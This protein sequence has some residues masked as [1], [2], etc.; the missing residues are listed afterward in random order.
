MR[1]RH[2]GQARAVVLKNMMMRWACAHL[3]IHGAVPK[4]L[5]TIDDAHDVLCIV[6]V[7]VIGQEPHG[8]QV[9]ADSTLR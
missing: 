8:S 4:V 3:L 2:T 1:F 7:A 9:E 6:L 5:V